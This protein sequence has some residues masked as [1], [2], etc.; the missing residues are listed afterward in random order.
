MGTR[1]L[2]AKFR[3]F[4]TF[5]SKSKFDNKIYKF[6][7]FKHIPD[8]GSRVCAFMIM[9]IRFVT[10]L[11]G[12][13]KWQKSGLCKKEREKKMFTPQRL[14]LACSQAYPLVHE[15]AFHLFIVG[16][17][18][19]WNTSLLE[20]WWRSIHSDLLIYHSICSEVMIGC[21]CKLAILGILML[22][23]SF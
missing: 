23:A 22:L 8:I 14:R 3:L 9:R 19:F 20:G 17:I 6:K 21:Y 2:I 11:H 18:I 16:N 1:D 4:F 5:P 12:E 15:V 10:W 7:H 13:D